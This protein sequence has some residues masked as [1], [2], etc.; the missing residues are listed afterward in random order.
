MAKYHLARVAVVLLC[1][2][3]LA[4]ARVAKVNAK[5]IFAV[6]HILLLFYSKMLSIVLFAQRRM[7]E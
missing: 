6:R 3:L 7:A 5:I 4:T 1:W 2:E